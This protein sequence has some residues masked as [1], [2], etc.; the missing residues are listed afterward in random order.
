MPFLSGCES[1]YCILWC[2]DG[3]SLQSGYVS[4][5][6]DCQSI[7]QSYVGNRGSGK[8]RNTALL[9][10]FA[11]CMKKRGWG[12]TSPKKTKTTKGGPNDTSQLSGDPWAPTPYGIRTAQPV[13]RQ[14][15][16]YSY[17][18]QPYTPSYNPYPQQRQSYPV[19]QN[20]GYAPQQ[21]QSYPVQQNYG[22]RAMPMQQQY[23]PS[24]VAGF[25][26]GRSSI[27]DGPY[28]P[29]NSNRAGIGLA[30]GF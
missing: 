9:E 4:D 2:H 26:R 8:A 27:L 14:P 17:Q 10:A 29:A 21:R 25:S 3:T 15:Q 24:P 11:K 30:P 12:V 23:N 19:Q 1:R 18:Q 7:A 6:D 28:A 20:Y 16:A 13:A 5:R 22:Y